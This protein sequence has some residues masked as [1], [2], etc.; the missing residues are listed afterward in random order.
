MRDD[1][2]DAQAAVDW[3]V[4]QIPALNNEFFSWIDAN[5]FEQRIEPYPASG[6]DKA[7]VIYFVPLPR[8]F[9]AWAGAIINSLRSSLDLLAAALAKRNRAG[10][11]H[12]TYFP[13]FSSVQIMNE[14]PRRGIERIGWL[15]ASDKAKIKS[16]Q[17]YQ[18][19]DHS[20]WPLHKLDVRRKHERFAGVNSRFHVEFGTPDRGE[21]HFMV[22]GQAPI[23]RSE[24][25]IV[26]TNIPE[27]TLSLPKR[28]YIAPQIAFIEPSLG[29]GDHEVTTTLNRFAER[30]TEII[31]MFGTTG[32]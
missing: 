6:N 16:L 32:C 23:E 19:G 27:F 28:D 18:G 13:I 11:T 8:V 3:A 24:N 25:R 30:V 20:I 9:N 26:L 7:L 31:N 17:P 15:S 2:L 14:D 1:L 21:G 22:Q 12:N 5:P 10:R 29:L 4:P